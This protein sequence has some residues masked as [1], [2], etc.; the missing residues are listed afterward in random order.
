MGE[1][2]KSVN[3][4]LVPS[5][6]R[7]NSEW[8]A[9][10]TSKLQVLRSHLF[11][12]LTLHHKWNRVKWCVS[13]TCSQSAL[14]V[15]NRVQLFVTPWTVWSLQDS[16][17][18]FCPWNFPSKNA[19]V[20]CHFLLQGIFPAQRLNLHLLHW[21][22]DSLP[23]VPPGKPQ[24]LLPHYI[25]LLPYS[26]TKVP[27][28]RFMFNLPNSPWGREKKVLFFIILQKNRALTL[29]LHNNKYYAE[30][31][32]ENSYVDYRIFEL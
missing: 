5:G 19:G 20:G 24:N 30:V 6:L 8:H 32:L 9:E 16:Q 15:L 28:L 12:L 2:K 31:I 17:G 10:P 18:I 1:K 29:C 7:S 23:L 26:S 25:N 3:V 21:Q 4:G 11:E 27:P 13:R 22:E 14:S